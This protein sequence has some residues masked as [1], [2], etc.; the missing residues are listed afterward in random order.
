MHLDGATPGQVVLGSIRKQGEQGD[1]QE[2]APF[3]DLCISS[4]L[5]VP[6]LF[7]FLSR[8]PLV[9]MLWK[10]KPNR[11]FPSRVAFDCGVHR[12]NRNSKASIYGSVRLFSEG[13]CHQWLGLGQMF[14]GSWL[15]IHKTEIRAHMDLQK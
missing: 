5:Q 4:C 9:L 15:L 11:P 8:L 14:L 10:W 6:T 13:F 2:A 3:C 12:S 1:G 7:E